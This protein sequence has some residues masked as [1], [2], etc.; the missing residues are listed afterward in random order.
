MEVESMGQL[1]AKVPKPR[2][3]Y[4]WDDEM[5]CSVCKRKMTIFLTVEDAG[6]NEDV[7]PVVVAVICDRCKGGISKL[8]FVL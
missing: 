1:K 8:P 3:G 4:Q 7:Y 6:R 2:L 5:E